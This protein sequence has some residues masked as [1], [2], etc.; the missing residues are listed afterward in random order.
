MLTAHVTRA[1]SGQ[2][3]KFPKLAS[4][5]MTETHLR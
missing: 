4:P 1:Q 3:T 5:H 2:K